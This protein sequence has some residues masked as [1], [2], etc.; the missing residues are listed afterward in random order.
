MKIISFHDGLDS[1]RNQ[2]KELNRKIESCDEDSLKTAFN[3][4]EFLNSVIME[5]LNESER[6]KEQILN[7]IVEQVC[8]LDLGYGIKWI[9][10]AGL[11]PVSSSSINEILGKTCHQIW[12]GKGTPC[13]QCP[14]ATTLKTGWPWKEE[15]VRPDG[16]TM[17]VSSQPVVD[18]NGTMGGII[19]IELDITMRKDVEKALEK[20]RKR[21]QALL[22]VIPDFLLVYNR[23]GRLLDYHPA[24]DFNILT[25]TK[26]PEGKLLGEIMPGTLAEAI[27]KHTGT[28]ENQGQSRTFEFQNYEC[29]LIKTTDTEN[30]CIVRDITDRKLRESELLK[31]SFHDKLTGLYNRGYFEEELTRI[32]QAREALPTSVLVIDVNNLKTNKRRLRTRLRRQTAPG[33]S[34]DSLIQ[35]PQKRR[36]CPDR[37]RRVLHHP[38]RQPPCEGGETLRTYYQR[39]QGKTFR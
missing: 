32:E 10:S 30:V 13:D 11:K 35:L 34:R 21:A 18:D 24:S 23:D 1:I 29:S 36:H 20:S 19:V 39:M 17:L 27:M 16:R 38:A 4:K 31:R 12:F 14:V 33:C 37:R 25:D 5:S 28:L 2:L 22:D 9:N 7:S 6:E 15:V 26:S 8:Y 3:K